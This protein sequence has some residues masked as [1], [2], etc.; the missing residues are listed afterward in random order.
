LANV[1]SD[2][3]GVTGQNIV[4]AILKGERD[5]RKL[6]ERFGKL[7]PNHQWCFVPVPKH[8]SGTGDHWH[9]GKDLAVL[10]LRPRWG[11]F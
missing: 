7:K 2:L 4:R 11:D 9:G 1:I 6:A 3:S 8:G 5:P 10:A